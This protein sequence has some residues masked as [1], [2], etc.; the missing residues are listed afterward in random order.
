M[1]TAFLFTLDGARPGDPDPLGMVD[2][3]RESTLAQAV[4][5]SLY[6]DRRAADDD[7]LPDST[8][9]RRGWWSDPWNT[10]PGDQFG[11]RLWLLRRGKATA[12]TIA[13]A[14]G[15]AIEALQWLVDLG[16]ATRVDVVA[17]RY[18]S[19]GCALAVTVERD[20]GGP[21]VLRFAELW[22]S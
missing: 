22:E 6:S 12:E 17:E 9:D 10:D 4:A 8:G 2:A 15:Y 21:V 14:R 11:S 13:A 20:A 16:I 3:G 5:A 19:N 7:A 18:S 1:S